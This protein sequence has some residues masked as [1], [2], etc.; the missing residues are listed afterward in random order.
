MRHALYVLVVSLVFLTC[1]KGV[2][3]PLPERTPRDWT[4]TRD[5]LGD[6]TYQ[7][8][9]RSIWGSSPEDV[10]I[11][12]HASTWLVGKIWHFDGTS[13]EDITS[14]YE[15]AFPGQTIYPFSVYDVF[16]SASD[17]L[18]IVG[19]R[20][21]SYT[22][23]V[24]KEGFVMHY[25]GSTWTGMTITGAPGLLCVFTR[26][27]NDVWVGGFSGRLHHF[28]GVSWSGYVLSDT[29]IGVQFFAGEIGTKLYAQGFA[30][31]NAYEEYSLL[32]WDGTSWTIVEN[33]IG[34][35][36]HFTTL[37]IIEGEF[38]TVTESSVSRRLGRNSWQEIFSDPS[39]RFSRVVGVSKT[40]IL[41]IGSAEVVEH[42][43]G[44]DWHRFSQF[45]SDEI[46]YYSGW[47]ATSGAFILGDNGGTH[48]F[49]LQ[50]K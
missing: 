1:N 45:H 35:E 16:G 29:T 26:N 25:N 7:I 17:N 3:P 48:C 38:Y 27:P 34:I 9:P 49:V 37:T 40:N 28:D 24:V 15:E 10:Y 11:A 6:G 22:P 30:I 42:F 33:A 14:V 31:K 41:A 43:N 44:K 47:M 2:E 18:W 13:W 12:G 36:K 32:E 39:A 23:Q 20:D 5:T 8:L 19:A 50:G 46:S 4:W 21:T